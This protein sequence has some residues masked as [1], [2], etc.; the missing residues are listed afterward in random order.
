M[1]TVL[2]RT[3]EEVMTDEYA[4]GSTMSQ[5]FATIAE[6]EAFIAGHMLRPYFEDDCW[7][8]DDYEIHP[9]EA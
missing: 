3:Y 4:F 7:C 8:R 9:V 2:Y 6:C 5:P 1:F